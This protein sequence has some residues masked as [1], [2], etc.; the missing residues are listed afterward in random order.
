[1]LSR[2]SIRGAADLVDAIFDGKI[3]PVAGDPN[4]G[5]AGLEFAEEDV[6]RL[7]EEH[8][9]VQLGGMTI[10]E[11]AAELE[12]KAQVA[13]FLADKGI[14]GA[15][16]KLIDGQEMWVVT[17]DALADFS[18]RYVL[19]SHLAKNLE[20]SSRKLV[21]RLAAKGIA[22]VSGPGV[23]G[24]RQFVF[25]RKDVTHP[26]YRLQAKR[27]SRL[28]SSPEAAQFL[29][30]P[31]AGIYRLV[32]GGKL[33]P[34][35]PRGKEV[36]KGSHM[37]FTRFSLERCRK[38]H[39]ERTDLM[40]AA[41]AAIALGIDLSH[42][43]RQYIRDGTLKPVA[44]MDQLGKHFFNSVDIEKLVDLKKSTVSGAEAAMILGVHRTCIVKWT[45]NGKLKAISGPGIDGFGCYRYLKSDV[46]NML[47]QS[48]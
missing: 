22:P 18:K 40:T 47:D 7:L 5:L 42:F 34:H 10:T 25:R 43:Y 16:R 44:V 9:R 41:A 20:T 19:A 21:E 11:A 8:R 13:Y 17:K 30:I 3:R 48:E 36:G 28:L 1:M 26:D 45:K 24:G 2:S 39:L 32:S 4:E 23:D 27:P 38:L 37:Q 15:E 46:E 31:L 29:G 35:R 14:L 6:T 33:S 12:I